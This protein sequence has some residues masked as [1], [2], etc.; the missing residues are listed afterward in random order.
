MCR[1]GQQQ[2]YRVDKGEIANVACEIE[3]NPPA[4]E[5]RWKFKSSST[6]G[7]EPIELAS[8][9][10]ENNVLIFKP[11]G[12]NDYGSVLCWSI[13]SLGMQTDPCVF[14]VEPAGK[15]EQLTNCTVVNQTH[16]SFMVTCI[17]GYDGGSTQNYIAE[18]YFAR[19][20]YVINSMSSP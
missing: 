3:S 11:Q 13:N 7:I 14:G 6:F 5:Y 9:D 1:P 8:N 10:I 20:K 18:L 4:H 15:P 2:T 16:Y 17:A 12:E 19:E